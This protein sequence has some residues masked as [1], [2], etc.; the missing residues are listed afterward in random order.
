MELAIGSAP[1]FQ[2]K[3][4]HS[5]SY[6]QHPRNLKKSNYLIAAKSITLRKDLRKILI[7]PHGQ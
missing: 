5:S 2:F 3:V 1:T 4:S 6:G 7:T